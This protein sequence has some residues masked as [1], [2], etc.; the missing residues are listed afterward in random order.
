M[1]VFRSVLLWRCRFF[2][3]CNVHAV[4]FL[5]QFLPRRQDW[6]A[7]FF[8]IFLQRQTTSSLEKKKANFLLHQWIQLTFSY[9]FYSSKKSFK[10]RYAIGL[11][12][13]YREL[14]SMILPTQSIK[15]DRSSMHESLQLD[16]TILLGIFTVTFHFDYSLLYLIPVSTAASGYTV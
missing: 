1:W 15:A 8:F 2:M 9:I 13:L 11:L 10:K 7:T 16:T 14:P 3:R 6:S 4:G 12:S 5:I